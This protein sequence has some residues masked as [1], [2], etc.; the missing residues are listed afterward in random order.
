[1]VA[2]FDRP[3]TT[4]LAKIP[5]P[6][7]RVWWCMVNH[8]SLVPEVS[9]HL[10]QWCS[11]FLW[12]PYWRHFLKPV[13]CDVLWVLF[14]L[15]DNFV[16]AKLIQ[17][18][19]FQRA[20]RCPGCHKLTHD[21][22]IFAG[23]D[24]ASIDGHPRPKAQQIGSLF[25][26]RSTTGMIPKFVSMKPDS[27]NSNCHSNCHHWHHLVLAFLFGTHRTDPLFCGAKKSIAP[28]IPKWGC[29]S[30]QRLESL[31]SLSLR[32]T[33]FC[34][35]V[36]QRNLGFIYFIFWEH[37]GTIMGIGNTIE[38]NVL[39]SGLLEILM[40]SWQ[41]AITMMG[42]YTGN[43]W[44]SDNRNKKTWESTHQEELEWHEDAPVQ[45]T[46]SCLA[47][48]GT[49]VVVNPLWMDAQR[50]NPVCPHWSPN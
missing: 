9:T 29:P 37:M 15:C 40:I 45:D 32:L 41:I 6:W 30:I 1:M 3:T 17:A 12:F 33:V 24:I 25:G 2:D 27:K 11:G 18:G 50:L 36:A 26:R 13:K 5:P 19:A 43:Q 48:A 23:G 34:G 21:A 20:S 14:G 28:Q 46:R 8:G 38:M 4:A 42:I 7:R 39:Y 16:P 44:E 31:L 47:M 49:M 35:I 10:H 22:P